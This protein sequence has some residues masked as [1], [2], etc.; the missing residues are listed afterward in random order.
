MARGCD[1]LLLT[2]LGLRLDEDA[3]NDELLPLPGTAPV[4]QAGSRFVIASALSEDVVE[5]LDV[6]EVA[7][8]LTCNE[9]GAAEE[10]LSCA[11][12]TTKDG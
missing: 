11:M 3:T 2:R 5:E 10:P 8:E 4:R 12:V 1:A 7:E 9:V 6:V